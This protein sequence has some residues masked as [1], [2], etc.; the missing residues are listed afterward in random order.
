M[1]RSHGTK[2]QKWV[3]ANML[4]IAYRLSLLSQNYHFNSPSP[5]INLVISSI[6]SNGNGGDEIGFIANDISF[7]GLSSAATRL[8]L[9]APHN[10]HRWMSAHSPFFL[11]HT[12]IGSIILPQ[13]A[14][15]SP[16]SLS[17][18]WL[19]RHYGQWLRCSLPAPVGTTVFPQTLQ[20]KM[21]L[22]GC[23]L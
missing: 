3:K 6:F 8:E 9:N 13:S 11:T 10:L 12:A 18:C 5:P 2:N 19:E 23:V 4:I 15:L 14:A 21:S 7:M 22:H 16:G 17:R 1:V 20:I